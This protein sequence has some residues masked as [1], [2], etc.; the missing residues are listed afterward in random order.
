MRRSINFS[1]APL[2]WYLL[3]SHIKN[4]DGKTQRDLDAQ[5]DVMTQFGCLYRNAES[6]INCIKSIVEHIKISLPPPTNDFYSNLADG[7]GD[8]YNSLSDESWSSRTW[9]DML[10]KDPRRYFRIALAVEFSLAR[11]RCPAEDDFPPWLRDHQQH[12]DELCLHSC[13]SRRGSDLDSVFFS[14]TVG[15]FAY[16][17]QQAAG[18]VMHDGSHETSFHQSS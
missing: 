17:D 6:T 11:G 1:A 10:L 12:T 16:E 18:L 7:D 13:S 4:S 8:R 9:R 15:D 14:E 5:F 3:E 2:I